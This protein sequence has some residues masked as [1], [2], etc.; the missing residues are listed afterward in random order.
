MDDRAAMIRAA[1]AWLMME[2][3]ALAAAMGVS[4]PTLQ[5]AERGGPVTDKTWRKVVEAAAIR[6]LDL[7][8]AGAIRRMIPA[9]AGE[10][11]PSRSV[12]P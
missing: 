11:V 7:S 10:N 2:R 6:G 8:D 1:R 4:V 9:A 3:A 12:R 5:R